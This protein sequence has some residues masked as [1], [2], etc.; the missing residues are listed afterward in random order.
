MQTE[1]TQ[2]VSAYESRPG[3]VETLELLSEPFGLSVETLQAILQVNSSVYRETQRALSESKTG[4]T[5]A[6]DVSDALFD[7]IK[8]RF[9]HVVS[10]TTCEKT[11]F[12]YGEFLWNERKG[13]NDKKAENNGNNHVTIVNNHFASLREERLRKRGVTQT[14]APFLDIT[15]EPVP[16]PQLELQ[17][18]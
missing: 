13:R 11:L 9:A 2:I 12:K 15:P 16:Q 1:I 14:P 3:G 6:G 7:V 10:N 8:Q 4:E 18:A 5:P 17:L